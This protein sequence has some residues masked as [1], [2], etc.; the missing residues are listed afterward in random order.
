MK[1]RSEE[2]PRRGEKASS[3]CRAQRSAMS[4][5]LTFFFFPSPSS[6]FNFLNRST[7]NLLSPSVLKG[8]LPARRG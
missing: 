7:T 3:I 1:L 6:L 2:W 5:P 4:T 8:R